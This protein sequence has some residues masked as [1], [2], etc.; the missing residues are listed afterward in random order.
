MTKL[1]KLKERLSKLESDLYEERCKQW[2]DLGFSDENWY[3][4]QDENK[5]IKYINGKRI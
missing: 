2:A 4:S 5:F 3:W 1:E